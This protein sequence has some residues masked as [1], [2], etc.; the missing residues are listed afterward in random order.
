MLLTIYLD[1]NLINE[2]GIAISLMLSTQSS[3]VFR[4]DFIAPQSD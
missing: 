2:K 3:R 4:F 1:E